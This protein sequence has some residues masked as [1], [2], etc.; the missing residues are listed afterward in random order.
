MKKIDAKWSFKFKKRIHKVFAAEFRDILAVL[1]EDLKTLSVFSTGSK[2]I[3]FTHVFKSSVV[4]EVEF[5]GDWLLVEY[6]GGKSGWI[7]FA[8]DGFEPEKI[9]ALSD[10]H[11]ISIRSKEALFFSRDSERN[12]LI[13]DSGSGALR[14]IDQS[15]ALLDVTGGTEKFFYGWMEVDGE[16][17]VAIGTVDPVSMAPLKRSAKIFSPDG[18]R[19]AE[20]GVLR[21]TD[22]GFLFLLD[23]DGKKYGWYTWGGE[24]VSL[25]QAPDSVTSKFSHIDTIVYTRRE[26]NFCVLTYS[27]RKENK[28]IVCNFDLDSGELVW[29]QVVITPLNGTGFVVLDGYLIHALGAQG[30]TDPSGDGGIQFRDESRQVDLETGEVGNFLDEPIGHWLCTKGNGL[31][32]SR[33]SSGRSDLTYGEF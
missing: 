27:F 1:H 25:F 20:F 22:G 16:E 26:K 12:D 17:K 2:E 10:R 29:Q 13:F 23:S 15:D 5:C 21:A 24:R 33:L 30:C 14:E 3:L 8:L 19:G 9:D 6:R 11:M 7:K 18:Q 28:V 32:F 4:T 31:F